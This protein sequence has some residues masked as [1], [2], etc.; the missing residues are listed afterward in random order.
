MFYNILGYLLL[1]FVVLFEVIQKGASYFEWIT[2][3]IYYI[4]I[5]YIVNMLFYYF[6]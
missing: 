1:P 3:F 4:A 6:M 5:V 2:K